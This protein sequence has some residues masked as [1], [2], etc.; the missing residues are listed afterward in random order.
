MTCQQVASAILGRLAMPSESRHRGGI[1]RE[2]E[3]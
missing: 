1:E 2:T 3:L